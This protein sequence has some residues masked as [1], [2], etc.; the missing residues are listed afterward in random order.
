MG[1]GYGTGETH[2]LPALKGFMAAIPGDGAYDYRA[3]E[4]AFGPTVAWLFINILC[5]CDVI[6]YGTSPRFGFLTPEGQAL[7]AYL[8]AKSSDE[9][10]EVFASGYDGYCHPDYCNCID[11]V[12]HNPFWKEH[13]QREVQVKP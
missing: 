1:F 7:K 5:K 11:E 3:L 6:E 10:A 2:T 4:A 12:C 8:A 13:P 9:L